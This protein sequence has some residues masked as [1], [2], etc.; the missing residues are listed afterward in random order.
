MRLVLV[1]LWLSLPAL[2]EVDLNYSTRLSPSDYLL[3]SQDTYHDPVFDDFK[4]VDLGATVGVGSDCGRV[5]FGSTLRTSLRN[6]LDAKYFLDIGKNIVGASPM[7][8]ACYFS[9]TWCAI[10]K[11]SQISAHYLSQMRLNQCSLIDKYTDSRVEDFYEARQS[12]VRKSIEDNGGD[13][14]HAME[15]CRGNG[16]WNADLPNW[17]GKNYGETVSDNR[18]LESSAKWAGFEGQEAKNSLG[19]LKSFVGD[20]VVSRGNVSVE[21][22]PRRSN[23]TPRTYLQSIEKSNYETLCRKIMKKVVEGQNNGE[24]IWISDEELKSISPEFGRGLIDRGTL[25]ALAAMPRRK[26]L[27]AC[28]MLSDAVSMTVFSNNIN[29]SL[30]MLTT[31]SQNPNLP[32][33]RKRE[34][35]EKRR[36]F[37]ESIDLAIAL[38]KEKNVPLNTALYKINDEGSRL[39]GE[40]VRRTLSTDSENEDRETTR[41]RLLDCSDGLMCDGR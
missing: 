19:L 4:T 21:Y 11:H 28:K 10:L 29:R 24:E 13:L 31:M 1:V 30:D 2:A 17:A 14:E 3:K 39:Q 33:H 37:K 9:P 35:E 34:I 40:M 22:G 23:L 41:A 5:D 12:C 8:L 16:I 32:P 15:S 38:Q 6:V 7:L 27:E 25:R 20:T 18:L 26:Q 36:A